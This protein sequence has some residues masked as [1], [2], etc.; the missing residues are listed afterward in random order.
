MRVHDQILAKIQKARAKG[1]PIYM[2]NTEEF[3][4]ARDIAY[5]A[6]SPVAPALQKDDAWSLLSGQNAASAQNIL[7]SLPDIFLDTP[8]TYLIHLKSKDTAQHKQLES[9]AQQYRLM[10]LRHSMILL[11]GR[12]E[13]LPAAL[14]SEVHIIDAPYPDQEEIRE[15]ILSKLKACGLSLPD[16]ALQSLALSLRGFTLPQIRGLLNLMVLP[17]NDVYPIFSPTLYNKIIREEKEQV[18]LQSGDLLQLIDVKKPHIGGMQ[19][20]QEEAKV[21]KDRFVRADAYMR[22]L[23]SGAP[24][25]LLIH[26]T[27]G[28]G[29]SAAAKLLSWEWR[30]DDETPMPLLRMDMGR[31]MGGYLGDSER[32]LRRALTLV[33]A[34]SPAI[35]WIDEIEKGLSG[36]AGGDQS[37]G[38][39][40]SGRMFSTLLTWL[41]EHTAPVFVY[42][43][44]NSLRDL[45]EELTR[46]ER[47]DKKYSIFLPTHSE[48]VDIMQSCMRRQE[49]RAKKTREDAG[50]K[51]IT[52]VFAPECYECLD[53]LIGDT[54]D[55]KSL[56]I[57][58]SHPGSNRKPLFVTGAD[59]SY[60][61]S[62]ASTLC[63]H[64]LPISEPQ[65]ISALQQVISDPTLSTTGSGENSMIELALG[66]IRTMRGSFVPV[67]TQVFFKPQDYH[68]VY[69]KT[70]P[71]LQ[72]PA[73]VKEVRVTSTCPSE[74]EYDK[75]L[76]KE[77][78]DHILI[79]A[80]PYEQ[81]MLLQQSGKK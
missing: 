62:E 30:L 8:T 9:F 57:S 72:H 65:W 44:C 47:L 48:C 26:G 16:D 51:D 19:R 46:K 69:A 15:R 37:S 80:Q 61:I 7:L 12:A 4:L 36:M 74:C 28:C 10:K 40:T 79:M 22:A 50:M 34:M 66:C 68:V 6:L 18:L 49:D 77:A 41:Q 54:P 13:D 58:L 29:K 64:R 3:E 25:G 2:I 63:M 23:G 73:Q 60:I 67:S 71:E 43:T 24:K 55:K 1:M 76:F 70:D 21:L 14:R 42:A 32:L 38:S 56:H 17:E 31:L 35:L 20:M 11:Y 78:L 5:H 33:E 39:G 27:Q 75:L 53:Q 52:P 81:Q 45:P 59:I